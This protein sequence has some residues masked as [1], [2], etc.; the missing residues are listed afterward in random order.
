MDVY[1]G[2]RY[3]ESLAIRDFVQH[4]DDLEVF[5]E[6]YTWNRI[7]IKEFL[8]FEQGLYEFF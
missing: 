8:F 1:E 2:K 3:D 5:Y 6:G 4:E 7:S